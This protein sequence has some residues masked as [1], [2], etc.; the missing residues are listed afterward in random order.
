[1]KKNKPIGFVMQIIG[2]RWD[3]ILLANGDRQKA[4]W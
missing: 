2:N 1:M 3:K 4:D